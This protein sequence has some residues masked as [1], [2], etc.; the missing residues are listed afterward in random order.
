ML[1]HVA[2]IGKP[3]GIRGEVTVQ[4]FTDDPEARFVPGQVL[5]TEPASRGPLTVAGARWNKQILVLGFDEVV[6]RNRAEELRGTKLFVDSDEV[7]DEDEGYYEHDLVG[8]TV[9]V[10]GAAVGTVSELVTAAA[11]DLLVVELQSGGQAMVPFVDEIVPEIDL[12]QGSVVLTPPPGL[13]E[14]AAE[15]ED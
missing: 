1:L 2:R 8:L 6:D 13:L 9:L 14:L 3:H 10:D 15:G 5:V 12:D 4:V 11:Q 7:D